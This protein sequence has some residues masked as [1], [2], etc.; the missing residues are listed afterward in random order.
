MA[1]P[2]LP[3]WRDWFKCRARDQ[4]RVIS[5]FQSSKSSELKVL[6]FSPKVARLG[7]YEF[8]GDIAMTLCPQPHGR[9]SAT[10][11]EKEACLQR[12]GNGLLANAELCI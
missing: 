10:A 3:R 5:L 8:G 2:H 1:H 12:W 9:S 11:E 7:Y 6:C 4:D